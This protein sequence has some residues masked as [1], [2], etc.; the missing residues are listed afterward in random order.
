V[1]AELVTYRHPDLRFS[2]AV[3]ADIEIHD[4]V[5]HVAVVAIERAEVVPE[6]TFRASL[7]VVVEDGPAGMDLDAYVEGSLDQQRRTLAD[8]RLLDREETTLAGVP[9]VRTL[10][11]YRGSD[12]LA[13]VVEQWR[14]I[15]RGAGWV[16]TLSS[17]AIGYADRAD[18]F[19]ASAES[20]TVED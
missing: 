15:K 9:A 13:V 18:A 19:A 20:L 7:N 10:A 5:P 1:E 16:V 14:L 17:D 12:V 2:I 3:P 4:D 8:F 6:G 11:H